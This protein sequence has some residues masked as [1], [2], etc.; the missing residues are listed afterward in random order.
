MANISICAKVKA[1]K[2]FSCVT[3]L[4]RKYYQQI[5]IINQSD[6][7]TTSIVY[8]DPNGDPCNFKVEFALKTG[9]TGYLV[10]LPENGSQ[11]F[12]T[13]NKTTSDLGLVQY[14]HI[15]NFPVIG[16]TEEAK[17]LL[18]SLDRGSVVVAMQLKDGTVEIYGLQNGLTTA[19]YTFDL[20]GGSGGSP[21]A[22]QSLENA[23]E[24]YI[25]YLLGGVDPE[26]QF[27]SLFANP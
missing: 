24:P 10:A 21:I 11:V 20:Q 16:A 18:N 5:V 19:D 6:I 17:C 8:P 9:T 12:G 14:Q 4:T 13:Y 27:D 23:P 26:A 7:D 3:N 15:T 1:G 25:P 22:L 2:D